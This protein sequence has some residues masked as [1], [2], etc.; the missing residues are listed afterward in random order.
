MLLNIV[1]HDEKNAVP[2]KLFYRKSYK[3]LRNSRKTNPLKRL[4]DSG[5]EKNYFE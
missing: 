1:F 2:Q 5:R 4:K 3:E